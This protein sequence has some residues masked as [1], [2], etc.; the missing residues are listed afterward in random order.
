MPSR[1]RVGLSYLDGVPAHVRHLE[2]VCR[3]KTQDLPRHQPET[4]RPAEL[5]ALVEQQL[6]P[7]AD[8]QKRP[9]PVHHVPDHIHQPEALK[10]IHAGVERAHS[11]QHHPTRLG[12]TARVTGD[13]RHEAHPFQPL[14]DAP[15][16]AHAVVDDRDHLGSS[17]S[18]TR[19]YRLPFVESTPSIRSSSPVARSMARANPLKHASMTWCGFSPCWTSMCRFIPNWLTNAW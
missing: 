12:D 13:L 19:P 10:V 5:L 11:G 9:L 3:G 14:L 17:E 4:L 8:T 2:I 7:Q 1:K 16:I 6:Q 18:R 15:Q